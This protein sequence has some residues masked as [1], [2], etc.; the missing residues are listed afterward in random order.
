MQG[1]AGEGLKILAV[2]SNSRNLVLLRQILEEAGYEVVAVASLDEFDRLVLRGQE[3]DLALV[4]ITGFDQAIWSRCEKLR[5]N[6]VPLL[7]IGARS[8]AALEQVGKKV[9]AASVLVKPLAV[10][11]L[12]GLIRYLVQA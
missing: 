11:E 9:G 4:D 7:L 1:K 12:V 3:L 5:E 10:K 6:D 2:S 8:G